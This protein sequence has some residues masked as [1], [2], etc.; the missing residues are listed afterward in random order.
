MLAAANKVQ[1][2]FENLFDVVTDIFGEDSKQADDALNV[3]NSFRDF[4]APLIGATILDALSEERVE[5]SKG[6]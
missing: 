6:K 1:E 4:V 3:S 5:A 2:Q